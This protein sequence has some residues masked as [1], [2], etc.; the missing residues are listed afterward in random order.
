MDKY[1]Q[2]ARDILEDTCE[3]DEIFEDYDMDLFEAGYLNSF[4]VLNI[5]LDIEKEL[6]IKLQPT[7]ISGDDIKSVSSFIAYITKLDS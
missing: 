6:G 5:I 1:E 4:A 7:D 2:I 3:T